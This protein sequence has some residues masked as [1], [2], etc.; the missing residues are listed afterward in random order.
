MGIVGNKDIRAGGWGK[1]GDED[2]DKSCFRCGESNHWI[3]ECQSKDSVCGWCGA[4]GHSESRCY[5][6]SDGH[7]RGRKSDGG[8]EAECNFAECGYAEVL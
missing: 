7:S 3:M 8:K 1:G 6:K 2:R 5:D 4:K